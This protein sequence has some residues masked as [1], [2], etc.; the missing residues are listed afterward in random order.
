M[1]CPKCGM[2]NTPNTPSCDCGYSFSTSPVDSGQ[3]MPASA[4]P[5][6]ESLHKTCPFCGEQ[7][8]A[9]AKKCKHCSEFLEDTERVVVRRQ[10]TWRP[11]TAAFLS[12]LFP[13]LGQMYKGQAASGLLWAVVVVAL[14]LLG[15]ALQRNNEDLG[16]G[17]FLLLGLALHILCIVTSAVA[18]A[19][20]P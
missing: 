7:I 17:I 16:A 11:W 14:Y 10:R 19:S 4:R 5:E 13:G 6:A 3:S 2:E 20:T 9:V 15:L 8:L 1:T 12:F 18:D